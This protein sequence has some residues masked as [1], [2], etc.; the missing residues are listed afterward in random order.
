MIYSEIVFSLNFRMV[1]RKP[2]EMAFLSYDFNI[3]KIPKG[4]INIYI[5]ILLIYFTATKLNGNA[6]SVKKQYQSTPFPV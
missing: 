6:T 2:G 1:T 5:Y 3:G 4:I